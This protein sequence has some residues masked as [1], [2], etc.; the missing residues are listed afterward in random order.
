MLGMGRTG[1]AAYDFFAGKGLAVAGIDSDPN[2]TD[3]QRQVFYGDIE[4]VGFWHHLDISDLVA[5]TLATPELESK[6]IATR[7]L[8]KAGFKGHIIAG[9]HF[10]DEAAP[11]HDAGVDQT[12]L[13]MA[14]AGIGI[15]EKTWESLQQTTLQIRR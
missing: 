11:L 8:R 13:L 5:V 4:D 7:E 3:A 6:L 9:I 10:N 12:Y 1:N 2:K 15:A 14:G